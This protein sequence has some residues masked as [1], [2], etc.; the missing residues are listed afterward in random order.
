M[1]NSSS[2]SVLGCGWLGVP[3]AEALIA[4]GFSVKGSVTSPEKHPLLRGKGIQPY[5][6]I[7]DKDH[8]EVDNPDFFRADLIIVSVPPRRTDDVELLFPA[9]IGQLIRLLEHD[10]I[11]RV[12]FISSTSVYPEIKGT[13]KESDAVSPDKAS[14][15]AL[16]E[17]EKLLVENQFFKT[18]V[19][20]F[21]GLIG[22][23]RDPARFLTRQKG[24]SDGSKPVNLIHRD[25]CI[26]IILE[27]I[28][29]EVWGET[30]NACCPVHPTRKEFYERAS[31]ISGIPAPVFKTDPEFS[32][33]IVDSSK[34]IGRLNYS[35]IYKSPMDWL[36]EGLK[37]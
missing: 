16:V 33:K 10:Q 19:V 1:K 6:L 2:I 28:R 35:F 13:V 37:D 21:G 7:L 11:P 30:F 14:G 5:H 32:W 20:R 3:L 24:V 27:L 26:R 4:E 18:T 9:Q 25:D 22:A 15:R 36:S 8:L 34:L 23:D 31:E 29:Q 12:L 17:A